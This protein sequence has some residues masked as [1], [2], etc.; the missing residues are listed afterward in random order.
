VLDGGGVIIIKEG[1]GLAETEEAVMV[2]G[3]E[4]WTRFGLGAFWDASEPAL[5]TGTIAT[6]WPQM[7]IVKLQRGHARH[8]RV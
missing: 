7:V 8:A 6:R 3:E 1:H 2:G 5:K 4:S